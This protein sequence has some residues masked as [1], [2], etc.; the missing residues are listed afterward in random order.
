MENASKALLMA[1]GILITMV[2]VSLGLYIMQNM[3]ESSSHF[4]QAMEFAEITKFNKKFTKYEGIDLT[5]QDVISILNLA[6]DNNEKYNLSV[7]NSVNDYID[8]DGGIGSLISDLDNILLQ[9]SDLY[10]SS[11]KN[12]LLNYLSNRI[13]GYK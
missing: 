7:N 9:N 2:V 1:G 3:A 5:M 10:E 4:Y 6:R 12:K 8:V 11:I 13:F